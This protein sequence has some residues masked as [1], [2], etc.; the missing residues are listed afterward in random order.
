MVNVLQ[1]AM[2]YHKMKEELCGLPYLNIQTGQIQKV[3]HET[4]IIR[5]E[6]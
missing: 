3:Q 5:Q 1:D 2:I 6:K 4:R